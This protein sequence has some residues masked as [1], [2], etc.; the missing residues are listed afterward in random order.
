MDGSTNLTLIKASRFLV[1]LVYFFVM[2]AL[3]V[4]L[5][6]FLLLLFGANP[7]AAFTEW[8][9]RSLNKVMAP[10]RGIFQAVDLSGNSVLDV[11]V[12]FAMVVYGIAG[13]ALRSL[14]DWLTYRMALTQQQN[15]AMTGVGAQTVTA[16]T[17]PPPPSA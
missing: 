10:F 7:D 12:L 5:F 17:P 4:L 2:V 11:S 1:Y 15:Q 16:G 8:V 13:L 14:I 6:G 3:V 9:Y